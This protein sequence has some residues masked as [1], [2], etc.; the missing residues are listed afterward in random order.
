M[1][2]VA[3]IALW[4]GGFLLDLLILASAAVC[5]YELL[6]LVL[7]ATQSMALRA[8][9]VTAGALY[10]GVAALSLTALHGIYVG[11]IVG[12]VVCTDTGAYFTGRK[13]GGPKIAPRISPSKTWSGLMGGMIAA[14]LW[15]VLFSLVYRSIVEPGPGP[16]SPLEKLP[17]APAAVVGAGLAVA[18]QAGD[19]LESWLKR[20]ARVKDSS[21]LIP[22]H[23]GLFDRIDGLLPVAILAQFAMTVA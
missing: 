18:A 11:M 9:A 5:L 1:L 23:G 21:N 14:A 19:F 8:V 16:G 3:G 10:V 6:Q 2:L 13:F 15:L 12:L 17:I 7:R 22:G 20:R 4:A